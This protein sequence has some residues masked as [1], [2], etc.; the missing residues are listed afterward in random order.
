MPNRFVRL[1][2]I[3][4]DHLVMIIVMFP[5]MIIGTLLLIGITELLEVQHNLLV[6]ILLAPFILLTISMQMR[7]LTFS[8]VFQIV[9][10][11]L[12]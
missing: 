3:L 6:I 12:W 9:G 11:A 8:F 2:S 10:T 4:F 7:F 5:F 1:G